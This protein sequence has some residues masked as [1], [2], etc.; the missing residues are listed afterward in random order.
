MSHGVPGLEVRFRPVTAADVPA[1]WSRVCPLQEAAA[2]AAL[3][4]ARVRQV[5]ALE[6]PDLPAFQ[7]YQQWS[8][9]L[10]ASSQATSIMRVSIHSFRGGGEE[11]RRAV[12]D[13]LRSLL[14][15]GRPSLLWVRSWVPYDVTPYVG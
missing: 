4:S 14:T 8:D 7:A 9:D 3:G 13:S 1:E 10:P 15:T 2:E 6:I 12:A 5:V 11:A